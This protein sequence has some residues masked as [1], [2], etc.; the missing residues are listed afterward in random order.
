MQ[1]NVNFSE[2]FACFSISHTDCN[3]GIIQKMQFGVSTMIDLK[4]ITT[5]FNNTGT[6]VS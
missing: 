1:K 5:T 6:L 4:N 3:T 2:S